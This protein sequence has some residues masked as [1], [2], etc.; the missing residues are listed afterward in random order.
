MWLSPPEV[1]AHAQVRLAVDLAPRV[2]EIEFVERA[3]AGSPGRAGFPA[4]TCGEPDDGEN[5]QHEQSDAEKE[6]DGASHAHAHAHHVAGHVA[7][8]HHHDEARA[9]C[10]SASSVSSGTYIVKF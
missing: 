2:P 7:M 5:G 4:Q 9:R 8:V 1:P 10:S 3:R 6:P